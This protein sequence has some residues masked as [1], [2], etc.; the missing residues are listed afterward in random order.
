MPEQVTVRKDE[1]KDILTAN[2]DA[3]RAKF[4]KA[5]EAYRARAVEELDRSLNDARQ[6]RAIRLAISLPVPED[7]TSDYDRE[8]RMLDLHQGDTV[9]L[10]SHEAEM[11]VMDRWQ[12]TPRVSASNAAYGVR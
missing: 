10:Q 5:Q 6:G 8:I 1:L 3:H 11:F 9:T 4:L 7:H 12:W 2:R